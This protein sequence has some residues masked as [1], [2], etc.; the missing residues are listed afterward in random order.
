MVRKQ[1][2]MKRKK[3]NSDNNISNGC[4]KRKYLETKDLEIKTNGFKH[5]EN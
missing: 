2:K 5:T 3:I 1:K 4:L